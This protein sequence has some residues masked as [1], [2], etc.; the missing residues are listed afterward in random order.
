VC[1]FT[2]IFL[3]LGIFSKGRVGK[4]GATSKAHASEN[5]AERGTQ[6]RGKWLGLNSSS[7][8]I[9]TSVTSTKDFKVRIDFNKY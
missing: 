7:N 2:K 5:G 3:N 8:T 1:K 9:F 6:Q 4:N